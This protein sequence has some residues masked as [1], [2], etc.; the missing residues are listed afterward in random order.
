MSLPRARFQFFFA[1]AV[2]LL[3]PLVGP[4]LAAEPA[5][6]ATENTA[7]LEETAKLLAEQF[8]ALGFGMTPEKQK[9]I[10]AAMSKYL[11]G[12]APQ[13]DTVG[14]AVGK[15]VDTPEMR[16]SMD[17]VAKEVSGTLTKQLPV[18]LQAVQPVM[19]DMLP[20]LLRMQADMLQILFS[21][22]VPPATPAAKAE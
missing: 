14:K 21:G 10:D 2:G 9:A 22:A 8:K 6:K 4:A 19:A 11:V 12:V 7:K 1:I 17:K 15:S 13:I 18:M 5:P 20:R 16:A 3:L